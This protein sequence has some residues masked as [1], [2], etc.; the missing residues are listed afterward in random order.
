MEQEFIL[1]LKASWNT[2]AWRGCSRFQENQTSAAGLL[3]HWRRRISQVSMTFADWCERLW[4]LPRRLPHL[5]RPLS[6]LARLPCASSPASCTCRGWPHAHSRPCAFLKA[7][8]K[9][10]HQMFFH[11]SSGLLQFLRPIEMGDMG[12]LA[13]KNHPFTFWHH[14][15]FTNYRKS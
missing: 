5:Q 15:G 8:Q 3:S 10:I 6:S 12:H 13:S 9:Q 7:H 4:L 14:I 2:H 1:K 11:R